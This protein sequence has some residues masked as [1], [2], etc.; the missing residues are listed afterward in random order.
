MNLGEN[1]LGEAGHQLVKSIRSW[2]DEPPLQELQLYNCSLTATASLELVQSLSSCRHLTELDLGQNKLGEAGHQLAQSIRS[3]GDEPPLQKIYLQNCSPTASATLQLVQSLSTCR[4]LMQL[5]LR[6]NK[7]GEAGLKLAQSIR[8]WGDNPSLLK[9]HLHNCSMLVKVTAELLKSLSTCKH[10]THLY[11]GRNTLKTAGHHLVTL[12]RSLGDSSQLQELNIRNCKMPIDIC[13]SLL[14]ALSTCKRLTIL[15]LSKNKLGEAGYHLA[16]SIRCWGNDRPLRKL[17]LTDTSVS[18]D[19]WNDILQSLVVCQR[20][21]F[22]D[23]PDALDKNG[24]Y[25]QIRGSINDDKLQESKVRK[26]FFQKFLN[27]EHLKRTSNVF[28]KA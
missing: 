14:Q 12:I 1:I 3:W 26:I 17:Y 5:N 16:Q 18:M 11:L 7:L 25:L 21:T 23:V 27:S 20:L 6:E 15:D 10:L 24:Y 9:L 8:S 13:S 22:L 28:S 19:I 4:Y 2:G